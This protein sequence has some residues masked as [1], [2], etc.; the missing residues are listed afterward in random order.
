MLGVLGLPDWETKK[1]RRLRDTEPSY[2][3]Q[4][5]SSECHVSIRYAG[6][7]S[8]WNVLAP[9]KFTRNQWLQP[10]GLPSCIRSSRFGWCV[11]NIGKLLL[12]RLGVTCV[13]GS[14]R[15]SG[16][17]MVR[18]KSRFPKTIRVQ[19]RDY[20]IALQRVANFGLADV[21]RTARR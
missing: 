1:A 13:F 4:F 3:K 7:A 19:Q 17:K 20:S 16:L 12:A 15:R 6:A 8:G 14:S 11:V 9:C 18:E 21:A 2:R 10:K 5:A